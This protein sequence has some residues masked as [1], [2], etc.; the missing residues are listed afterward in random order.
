MSLYLLIYGIEMALEERRREI[1]IKK[2]Q[3][4]NSRQIFNELRN[5]A[6]ILFLIGSI[7]GN[8]GG[9]LG[10]W[11]ISSAAGFLKF[12]VSSISD[13]KD[14]ITYDQST[15]TWTSVIVGL[16]LI[17]QIYKK[18][19]AFIDQEVSEAVQRYEEAK[20][21]F[22][23]RNKL[24]IV[25]FVI[26]ATGVAISI[27]DQQFGITFNLSFL[28]QLL[29]NGLGPF[30]FWI[31][32]ALVGARI[33]KK[34]PLKFEGI[35]LS[36]AFFKDIK[37]ILRSG[38]LRRG[39]TDRLA[40]I[41][42]LTLSIA[43]LAAAQGITDEQHSIRTLEWEVGSDFQVNY[44]IPGN[45]AD[46]IANLE[47]NSAKPVQSVLPLGI[48]PAVTILN[49]AFAIFG[50]DSNSEYANLQDEK[51]T[52]IWH[53]DAFDSLTTSE[54]LKLLNDNPLGIFVSGGILGDIIADVNDPIDLTV[55]VATSISVIQDTKDLKVTILG[56]VDHVP[57]G[58][59]GETIITSPLVINRLTSLTTGHPETFFDTSPMN[60]SKYL[61]KMKEG[62]SMSDSDI[63]LIKE[64]FRQDPIF[65]S[66]RSLKNEID[67]FQAGGSS[68]GIPGLLSLN[69][70]VSVSA[71]I[72]STFAFTAILMERRKGEFAVLRAIGAKKAQIYKIAIGEN[73]LF[74][75]TSV[76]WGIIIGSGIIYLFNGIFVAFNFIL[77]GGPLTRQ[78]IFPWASIILI[79]IVTTI[80]MLLATLLSVR[81]AAK[82]D[83]SVATRVV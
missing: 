54:A 29:I 25:F 61:L 62:N 24:D 10:A 41:I 60:A 47:I 20:V 49:R 4:A 16:I 6:V 64:V 34:V 42:V 70:I 78:I 11:L 9:M 52:G 51:S 75:T 8:F 50:L 80:G 48:G 46:L 43:T 53:D 21:G 13:F 40:I 33:S 31:G 23:R 26:G 58:L 18:G 83:L 55:V 37:T 38:L 59:G 71:A 35:L 15:L 74:V 73:I 72:I 30:F 14:F 3:G 79:G 69:F 28:F 36:V 45:Y 44:A 82:Q 12:Q 17:L 27:L 81:G 77:G 22:L 68:F 39:E 66:H 19:R 32:G 1:A 65:T 67:D 76:I 63:N 56:T 2:V 7:I 5:E 57:G